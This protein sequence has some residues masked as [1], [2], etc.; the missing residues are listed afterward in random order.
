MQEKP[1]RGRRAAQSGSASQT[2]RAPDG[3]LHHQ[4]AQHSPHSQPGSSPAGVNKESASRLEYLLR[5]WEMEECSTYYYPCHASSMTLFCIHVFRNLLR[6]PHGAGVPIFD[7]VYFAA[8][9]QEVLY[10]L[11]LRNSSVAS[12]QRLNGRICESLGRYSLEI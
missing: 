12:N 3:P 5:G 2:R 10:L 11:P 9:T 8:L 1:G 4:N 6:L 7:T